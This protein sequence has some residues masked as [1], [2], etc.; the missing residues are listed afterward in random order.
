MRFGTGRPR[1]I[2]DI[3]AGDFEPMAGDIE[4]AP[5]DAFEF[6]D[7]PVGNRAHLRAQ[8]VAIDADRPGSAVHAGDESKYLLEPLL[9]YRRGKRRELLGRK[10]AASARLNAWEGGRRDGTA[11]SDRASSLRL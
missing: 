11:A 6:G 10:R 9:G 5:A 4:R 7:Q 1:H 2:P 8:N 3:A